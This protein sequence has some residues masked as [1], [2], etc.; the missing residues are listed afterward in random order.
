[1]IFRFFQQ[2]NRHTFKTIYV[3]LVLQRK[4]IKLK[5]ILKFIYRKEGYLRSID[6][7]YIKTVKIKQNYQLN[8]EHLFGIIT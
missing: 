4:L 6:F 2:K 3:N 5:N 1:M 7:A 8:I